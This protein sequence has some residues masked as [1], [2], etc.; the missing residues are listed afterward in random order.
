MHDVSVGLV[1]GMLQ[2]LVGLPLD[3]VKIL[4]Q[5]GQ[6]F[7][8]LR[9]LQLYRGVSYPTVAS[10]VF[11][12]VTFPVFSHLRRLRYNPYASGALAGVSIAPINF[13]FNIGKIR[14]QTLTSVPLHAKGMGCSFAR[15][16]LSMA[17]YF[18][19]YS[20]LAPV[21]GALTAGGIAGLANWTLTYPL[22]VVATRQIAGR[23]SVRLALS[24]GPL[25][26]GYLPCAVR[27]V[28]VNSATFYVYEL[29]Q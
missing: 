19:V 17:V 18:G 14:R 22:D 21:C 27:A 1:I 29:L 23:L 8:S 3:T 13:A 10:L 24:S 7:R 15:S 4:L 28:V 9:P 6:P 5:N 16:V 20:D 26:R 12:A 11:N 25:M 2:S